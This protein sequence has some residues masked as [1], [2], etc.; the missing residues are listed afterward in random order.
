MPKKHC[1]PRLTEETNMQDMGCAGIVSFWTSR[2]QV[3]HA[4]TCCAREVW[5]CCSRQE[6]RALWAWQS[7]ERPLTLRWLALRF[8]EVGQDV[9]GMVI[10]PYVLTRS[11]RLQGRRGIRARQAHQGATQEKEG[12]GEMGWRQTS[13]PPR[14]VQGRCI[15]IKRSL[16]PQPPQW[17][18][19][20]APNPFPLACRQ[21]RRHP[22]HASSSSSCTVP[23]NL[24]LPESG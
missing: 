1:G 10:A 4:R 12:A 11:G 2:G 6:A 18:R 23:G 14:F 8:G 3:R 7:I 16:H 21:R 24:A 17:G 22:P 5:T 15:V 20:Y 9:P 19:P 13:S